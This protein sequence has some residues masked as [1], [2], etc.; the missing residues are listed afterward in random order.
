MANIIAYQSFNGYA[1]Q[2][3]QPTIPSSDY[4]ASF[5]HYTRPC[6]AALEQSFNSIPK[7]TIKSNLS[8]LPLCAVALKAVLSS[9]FPTRKRRKSSFCVC[10]QVKTLTLLANHKC[11]QPWAKTWQTARKV[12]RLRTREGAAID[13]AV[14]ARMESARASRTGSGF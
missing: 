8:C 9:T 7:M 12:D 4:N 13:L 1:M 10:L 14:K 2:T 6:A 3:T 5:Q 11:R